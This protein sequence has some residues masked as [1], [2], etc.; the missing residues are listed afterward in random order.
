MREW[1]RP[2]NAGSTPRCGMR[3]DEGRIPSR[4][5]Y[6]EA[7]SPFVKTTK[8]GAVG[9]VRRVGPQ[10]GDSYLASNV[11]MRV[12]TIK[13]AV[14]KQAYEESGPQKGERLLLVHGW[15]DSPR[16][17]D[18]VLP[19]LHE[20]GFRTV[21]PYLRGYGPSTFRD[22]LFGKKPRRSGQPVA[23]AED[24]IALADALAMKRFHYIGHDWG[25]RTAHALAALVP[26]RLKSMVTISVPYQPGK[27]KPPKF[28]QARAFWYQWLL[29][30]KPGEEKFRADPVAFGKAQWDAWSPAGW[31][32][33]QDL[34]A[35][36]E[37]WTGKDFEDTVL[38]GYRSRWGHAEMDP[39]YA[40]QQAEFEATKKLGV[41]TVLIHGAEDHCELEETTDGAGR[42]FSAGYERVVLPGVGHFPQREAPGP[43]AE[44]ILQHVRKYAQT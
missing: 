22:P 25:A 13:T 24:M 19:L 43:T 28:P 4:D 38:H 12:R 5:D 34:A 23:F 1:Q 31:Y 27:A 10:A 42:Y 3:S 41:P 20:A 6:H 33:A 16:T 15:P 9:W 26:E 17:W 14:L 30:T 18:K 7:Q 35:A 21:V 39:R 2:A 37:S 40:K 8:Q 11:I 44:A 36:A 29:C 32:T